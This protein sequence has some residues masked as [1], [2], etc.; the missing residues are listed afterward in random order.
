[1]IVIDQSRFSHASSVLNLLFGKDLQINHFCKGPNCFREILTALEK[2][3]YVGASLRWEGMVR[4][5]PGAIRKLEG[6]GE[7]SYVAVFDNA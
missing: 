3:P 4:N 2:F 7:K 5:R 6:L 1:M